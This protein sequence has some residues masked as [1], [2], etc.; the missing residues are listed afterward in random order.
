MVGPVRAEPLEGLEE[1]A[2]GF[3]GDEGPGVDY[4]QHGARVPDARDHFD[5]AAGDVVPQRVVYEVGDQA[6]GR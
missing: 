2:D 3:R 4:R 6:F 1:A 5:V